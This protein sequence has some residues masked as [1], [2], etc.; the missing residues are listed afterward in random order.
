M[1][2]EVENLSGIGVELGVGLGAV[3]AGSPTD[4]H[5]YPASGTAGIGWASLHASVDTQMQAPARLKLVISIGATG[6]LFPFQAFLYYRIRTSGSM[7]SRTLRSTLTSAQVPEHVRVN[8]S[9][10]PRLQRSKRRL[11]RC[12]PR[13]N[14][15][16][17]VP[18]SS[19]HPTVHSTP[20][21]INAPI[22]FKR[23]RPVYAPGPQPWARILPIA[24][25]SP[26]YPGPLGDSGAR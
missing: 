15:T 7:C 3:G 23:H 2:C 22:A 18:E 6:S 26:P 13:D 4:W 10:N 1:D 19:R 8:R 16:R 9:P 21:D 14:W 24:A 5:C 11:I 25:P 20:R 17:P 12:H